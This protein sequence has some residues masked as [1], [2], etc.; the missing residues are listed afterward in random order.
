MTKSRNN[1]LTTKKVVSYCLSCCKE[2]HIPVPKKT[3]DLIV[4]AMECP[5]HKSKFKRADNGVMVSK[6]FLNN[7]NEMYKPVSLSSQE[8]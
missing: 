8:I 3:T 5:K 1:K 6:A 7:F 4:V 2:G